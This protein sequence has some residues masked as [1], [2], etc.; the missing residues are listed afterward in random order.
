L[1]PDWGRWVFEQ[2]T[3]ALG[4][5]RGYPVESVALRADNITEALVTHAREGNYDGIIIGASRESLLKQ[6]IAGNIPEAVARG[7]DCTVVL[8]RL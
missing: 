8:V 7:S 6:A 4:R 2:G 1:P 5:D 3:A